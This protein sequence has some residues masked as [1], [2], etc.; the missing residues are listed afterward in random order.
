[1]PTI[2]AIRAEYDLYH[3]AAWLQAEAATNGYYLSPRGV[4]AKIDPDRLWDMPWDDVTEYA[5]EE[6]LDHWRQAGRWTWREYLAQALREMPLAMPKAVP[7]PVP[8]WWPDVRI[9]HPDGRTEQVT[10]PH[11]S[12]GHETEVAALACGRRLAAQRGVPV[13]A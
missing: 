10:C 4:A 11:Q 13:A 5:S 9:R 8:Y 1:V 3:H 7:R 2:K 12:Y 6:L